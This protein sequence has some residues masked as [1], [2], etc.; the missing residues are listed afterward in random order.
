M[1]SRAAPEAADGQLGESQT[2]IVNVVAMDETMQVQ[3]GPSETLAQVGAKFG[4]SP[5]QMAAANPKLDPS[6]PLSD[7]QPVNVPTGGSQPP[8]G[9]GSPGGGSGPGGGKVP[10][11][12]NWELKLNGQADKSYCYLSDG[13][14]KW[15]KMPQPPF[16]FFGGVD[17]LYTQV[18]DVTPPTEATI[19]AQ[20]WGWLGGVLK[21]LGQ[22]QTK[23][24]NEVPFR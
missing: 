20:C 1:C 23:V 15:E 12:I 13:S 4:A 6:T 22:G 17:N 16:E 8:G 9:G 5:D 14:G 10:F 19:Q 7:G 11:V 24:V 18:F 3:A 2:V 21:Y